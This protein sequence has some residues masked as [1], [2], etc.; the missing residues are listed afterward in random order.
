MSS[1][2]FMTNQS[3]NQIFGIYNG[4]P[5][6]CKRLKSCL[7]I[8]VTDLKKASKA[9]AK[10]RFDRWRSSTNIQDYL[11]KLAEKAKVE[12]LRAKNG[13]I[14]EVSG[15]LEIIS[16]GNRLFQ[17]TYASCDLAKKY[18]QEMSKDCYQWLN[19][20][21]TEESSSEVI[22]AERVK[23]KLGD[24]EIDVYEIPS[25]EYLLNQL[26]I[27]KLVKAGETSFRDFLTSKS[28]E[29]L[30]YKDS[31]FVKIKTND[32]NSRAKGIPIPVVAAYW[33]KEAIKGNEIASRLL[34]ACAIESIKRR[35]DKAFGKNISE[36]EYNQRFKN[37]YQ[38]I[39][40]N[41]PK[42]LIQHEK[43]QLKIAVFEGDTRKLNKLYP[44]GIIPGFLEKE[45]IVERLIAIS[46]YDECKPWQLTPGRELFRDKRT[47]IAKCPDFVSDVIEI[48]NK[49][50]IFIFQVY[51]GIISPVDIEQCIGRRYVHIAKK[52]FNVDFSFLFLVSPIGGNTKAV[53]AVE[54]ELEIGDTNIG[55]LTIKQLAEFYH[56]LMHENK[57]GVKTIKSAKKL[58]KPFLEYKIYS[59]LQQATQL[60]IEFP[61]AS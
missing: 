9:T 13:L 46:S 26:Q 52:Q 42:S 61:T 40:A 37:N 19:S 23:I 60:C 7:L 8:N 38:K 39:I 14:S 51:P 32:N 18:T 10:Y 41:C 56:D 1:T 17:G 47:K 3:E 30:P 48:D 59:P 6:K 29:A 12:P 21:L 27:A 5:I 43:A 25:G 55:I 54:D 4:V 35:A 24:F 34:G 16:G 11:L 31:R 15:V 2:L 53:S 36:E 33:T 20:Q 28:P 50:A 44:K 49:K 58:F 57:S 45:K 22:R